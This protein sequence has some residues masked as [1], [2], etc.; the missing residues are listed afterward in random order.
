MADKLDLKHLNKELEIIGVE[1]VNYLRQLLVENNKYASGDLIKS[2]DFKVIQNVDTLMLKLLASDHFKYVDE[3]RKK[4]KMPPTK[5]IERWIKQKNIKFSKMDSAQA[6]FVVAR[7][8]GRKGIKPMNLLN[9][10]T[11]NI[12]DKKAELLR[13]ATQEDIQD[14]IDKVFFTSKK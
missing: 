8:I 12:I 3:G 1:S 2:L 14:L 11:Q 4:G 10:L 13:N 5:P 7:S 9:R 6:A